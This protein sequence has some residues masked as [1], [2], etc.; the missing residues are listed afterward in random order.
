MTRKKWLDKHVKIISRLYN[1]IHTVYGPYIAKDG[2]RRVVIYDG[3]RRITRQYA[4]IKMEIRL[5]RRLIQNETVDH[6]DRNILNDDYGNLQVLDRSTHSRKDALKV[7]VKSKHK[8]VWCNQIIPLITESQRNERTKAGPFCS[9]SC[10]GSYG[11]ALQNRK[12][13]KLPR[14]EIVKDYYR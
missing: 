7:R 10:A 13:N 12:V 4:K 14:K 1:G 5:N 3:H 2:R 8:C 6:I 11:A 9:R